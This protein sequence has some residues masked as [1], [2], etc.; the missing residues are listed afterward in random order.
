MRVTLR[1]RVRSVALKLELGVMPI[2]M[3]ETRSEKQVL[4]Y[5]PTNRT[6]IG[7]LR[8]KTH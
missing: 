6:N 1:D 2:W 7:R 3:E 4:Q 5:T 8:K